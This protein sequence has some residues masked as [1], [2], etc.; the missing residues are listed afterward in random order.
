MIIKH[1]CDYFYRSRIK[2]CDFDEK[3]AIK[4]AFFLV[5]SELYVEGE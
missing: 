3:T 2:G 5:V 4:T 1:L